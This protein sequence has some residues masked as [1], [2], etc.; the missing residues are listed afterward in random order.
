MAAEPGPYIQVCVRLYFPSTVVDMRVGVPDVGR[1]RLLD[2]LRQVF[3][4]PGP[5][6]PPG[7]I[8]AYE[9]VDDGHGGVSPGEHL[10]GKVMP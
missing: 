9:L 2:A 4:D 8:S 10:A 1:E 6:F 5:A 3:Q 7:L